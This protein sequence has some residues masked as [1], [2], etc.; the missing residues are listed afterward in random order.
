MT[1]DKLK[2]LVANGFALAGEAAD[3]K[4]GLRVIASLLSVLATSVSVLA[5]AILEANESE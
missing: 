1:A 5:I 3:D 2:D 4:D